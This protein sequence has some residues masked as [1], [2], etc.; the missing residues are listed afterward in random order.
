MFIFL[1]NTD[2][3]CIFILLI[4]SDFTFSYAKLEDLYASY[5]VPKTLYFHGN[6]QKLVDVKYVVHVFI[7]NVSRILIK[8]IVHAAFVYMIDECLENNFDIR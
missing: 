3:Y 4:R 8:Q 2:L 6:S 5:V 7:T 1:I